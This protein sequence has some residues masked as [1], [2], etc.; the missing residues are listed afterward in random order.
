NAE[1]RNARY[2]SSVEAMLVTFLKRKSPFVVLER[3]NSTLKRLLEEKQRIQRGMT[4]RRPGDAAD[5]AL[6]EKLDAYILGSVTLL[7]NV[8]EKAS[9]PPKRREKDEETVSDDGES[10]GTPQSPRDE[11]SGPRIEIDAKLISRF[12]GRI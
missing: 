3:Q 2:G 11:I 5:R 12:D 7:S 9:I 6:L 4:E 1:A 10:S 8:N